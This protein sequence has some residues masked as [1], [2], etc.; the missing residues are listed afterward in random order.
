[1]CGN[2]GTK[3]IQQHEP[4]PGGRT[5]AA[6]AG[7]AWPVPRLGTRNIGYGGLPRATDPGMTRSSARPA[8]VAKIRVAAHWCRR[9][10]P[11]FVEEAV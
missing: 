11:Q 4:L 5:G 8:L 1:M 2:Q 6:H 9:L 7:P 3:R 10:A